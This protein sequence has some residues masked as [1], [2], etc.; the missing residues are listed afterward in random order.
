M[1]S[2]PVDLRIDARWVIPVVPAGALQEHSVL[3][4]RGRI[5]ALLPTAQAAGYASAREHRVLERHA[6]IP[7]LVNAHGH[8]AMALL[9]GVADD[10]PLDRWLRE[11]IWPREGK[12]VSVEFVSDGSLLAAAEMLRGG[13][14]C[15][16]DMYFF[17]EATAASL[18]RAGMRAMIGLAVLD[19]PTPYAAD[20]ADYLGKGLAMRDAFRHDP[21]LAFSLAPHAPYTVSD[22][23]L[24]RIVTYAEQL[25]LP[26]QIHLHE[27][28]TEIEDSLK[29]YGQR[30][31]ARLDGLGALGPGFQA[32]HAVHLSNEEISL[33]AERGGGVVHCPSSNLKLASGIA[34]V[35]AM[36]A[37][38]LELAL[39]TDGAASNNRLD[40][41]E[42]MRL[43][44]LLAKGASGDA[45]ALPAQAAL[46]CATLGGARVLG[47]SSAIGSLEVGKAA[48]LTAVDFGAIE[49]A[50]CYDP[51]SH[52]V[53]VA[54]R[55]DVSDVWVAG[56][57]V[58]RDRCLT[59]LDTEDLAARARYWQE[60]L[61]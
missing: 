55:K 54:G 12:H 45:A 1:K 41:F 34:P 57:T 30:P 5:V 17:P 2:E 47:W 48:D 20:A 36:R 43:A 51:V 35:A 3:I 42:E 53:Y 16:S 14:T 4:D 18:R 11:H 23:S 13:I 27:T 19:F 38:G 46:E 58:L 10:L 21:L 52:L 7:G 61:T 6:L 40:L 56:Q 44:A 29:Q 31:L 59:H 9:R 49:F 32:V 39:G 22:A 26:I 33:L 37:A 28:A 8:A 60:R 24:E 25:D 50:P 15:C